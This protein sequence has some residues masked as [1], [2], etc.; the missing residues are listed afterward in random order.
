MREE[1]NKKVGEKKR[2]KVEM[3][4]KGRKMTWV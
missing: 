2:E 3:K 4:G 1:R